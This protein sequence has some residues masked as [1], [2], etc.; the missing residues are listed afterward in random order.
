MENQK[1]IQK[2]TG[3][4]SSVGISVTIND[5]R[6]KEFN[7]EPLSLE[8]KQALSNYDKYRITELNKQNSDQDFHTRY[9]ELQVMA[10]LGNFSEFLSEKYANI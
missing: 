8:E 7:R 4:K 10:N 3:Q 1:N 5:L 9:R 6:E 2:K